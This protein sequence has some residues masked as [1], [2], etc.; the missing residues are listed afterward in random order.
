MLES[1][2]F[3]GYTLIMYAKRKNIVNSVGYLL[4]SFPSVVLL[5]ARQVGKSTLLR[6]CL[7]EAD[8]FDLEV[9]SDWNRVS[10]DPHLLFNELK[11]PFVFDEAQLSPKL[12]KALR[13][14]I[15]KDR[16]TNGRFLLS[17]S[18]SPELLKNITETLAG[19]CAILEIGTFDWS[20]S[21]QKEQSKFFENLA[22]IDDLL[23]LK[24]IHTHSELLDYCLYGGYPDPFLKRSD[25]NYYDIWYKDYIKSYVERDIRALFPTLNLDAYKRFIKMMATATGEII[26]ASNFAR[27]LDVSQ[28][29]V[30]KYLEIIEGTFLWRKLAPYDKVLKKRVVKMPRGHL[31]DT[32][33][34]NYFLNIYSTSDLKAHHLFGRIWEGFITEQILK[35]LE[36]SLIR[37]KAYFYRTNNQAEIDLILEGRFGIIPIEIKSGST[38]SK[39][40]LKTLS[41]FIKENKCPFGIVINNGTEIFKISDSI[42]Q[43]PAIF[44]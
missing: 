41:N 19:R 31:R 1:I 10:S 2:H 40:Q 25:K 37:H 4:K 26:N 27:S 21:G 42:I 17:G 34:T 33:L 12:F 15:D 35:N 13:V 6:R 16:K 18:S 3:K 24:P 7:P 43:I 38:T 20:E 22:S 44:I 8:Y 5:G 28:P 14:E 29:T 36:N 9:E 30:K 23:K 32:G 39:G 11:G